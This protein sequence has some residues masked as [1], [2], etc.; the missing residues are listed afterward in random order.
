MTTK[1]TKWT[2][3]KIKDGFDK[4]FNENNRYPT[5]NEIDDFAYL[6]SSRQIQRAWGGLVQ[7]R[8]SLGLPIENYCAGET[9]SKTAAEINKR[10]K[11]F[12][13]LVRNYLWEK[14][15]EP[16]VHIERPLSNSSKDRFDFYVYAKPKNFAIDVFATSDIRIL[17]KIMNIK[18]KKYRKTNI[19]RGDEYLYFIYFSENNLSD[20]I[21][22][23]VNR[24]KGDLPSNWKILD[25][26]NF[27][28]EI[29]AYNKY[30]LI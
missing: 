21:N 17:I 26:E 14:F 12:E 6:P 20:A 24:R 16:F 9:R 5:A 7:L 23:W 29:T 28:N 15:S 19:L 18:E 27:K 13:I 4:F 8:K 1:N 25:F 3:A 30:L 10:G 2:I 22:K 11:D